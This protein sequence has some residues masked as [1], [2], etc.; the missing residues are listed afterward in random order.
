MDLISQI[1]ISS[2]A[3]RLGWL[4]A[5]SPICTGR[6]RGSDQLFQYAGNL[7]DLPV[8][9]LDRVGQLPQ[10]LDQFAGSC[11]Q[12]AESDECP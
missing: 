11:Q 1:A 4:E 12:S 3:S 7:L 2:V 5:E 9:E 10:L 8:M 6:V